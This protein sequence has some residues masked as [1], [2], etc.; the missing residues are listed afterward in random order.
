MKHVVLTLVLIR[1]NEEVLLGLKKTGF[2]KGNWN[3]PGGKVEPGESIEAA[4]KRECLEELGV[5]VGALKKI[6]VVT[7]EYREVEEPKDM[8][9]H[10]F[11]THEFYGEPL[12]TEEMRPRWF[13]VS[14]YPFDK[15]W[16]DDVLWFPWYM[17]GKTFRGRFLF[18]GYQKVV[19]HELH[20]ATDL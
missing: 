11:E 6:G 1:R 9:V 5:D 8:E 15:A 18:H 13:P 19:E 16:P 12:E 4:A 20:E 14:K 10:I 3:G 17:E 2:G 7:C